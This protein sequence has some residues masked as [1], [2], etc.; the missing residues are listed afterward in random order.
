MSLQKTIALSLVIPLPHKMSNCIA[1]L[2]FVWYAVLAKL[3]K[4]VKGGSMIEQERI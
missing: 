4:K 1:L 3:W 2:I